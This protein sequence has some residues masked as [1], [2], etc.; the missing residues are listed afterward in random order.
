[1]LKRIG[2]LLCVLALGMFLIG[3]GG[4]EKKP[5]PK[6]PEKP[7]EKAATTPGGETP[8]PTKETPP[9]PTT[10]KPADKPEEKS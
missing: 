7:P 9:A 3:C 5:A 10:E 1:M 8:P 2:M 4:G 6:G